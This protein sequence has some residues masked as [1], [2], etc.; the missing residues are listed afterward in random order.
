[1]STSIDEKIVAMK[2]N[3]SDF[4]NNAKRSLGTLAALTKGLKLDGA[5]KGIQ[6]ISAA[7]KGL[8]LDGVGSNV[9]QISSKFSALGVVGVTALAT[10]AN[11]AVNVGLN[12]VKSLTISPISQGF[13][14]YNEKL[15]SVNTV[16]NATGKSQ[17]VVSK[18]FNELDKYADLTIYNLQDMT[19]ALAKFVNAGISL[20]K[21]VP[22]I[23]GIANMTALA[24]QGAGA[25]SI[26]MYNL[27]QSLAG[28]FLTTTDYKSLNLANV[29]TKEWKDNMIKAAVSAGTLKRV[30]ADS[31]HIV[32][33][34]AG[35]A[36]TSAA[37]FNEKLSDGWANAKILLKVLGDYG[38]PLTAIGRKALAA[39]QEVKSLPM[40]LETLRA[41]VGT[42]WTDTFEIVVGNLKE[43]KK[44]FT[45]LTNYVGT[46]LGNMQKARND[47]LKAW[48]KNGGRD[49]LI[50]GLK[51]SFQA[52]L[53]IIKPIKDAFTQI[54]PP[55]TGKRLAEM[56]KN[57][58][59]FTAG[60]KLGGEN[61][62]R[63]KRTF[64]GVFA[65]FKV[66]FTII[67]TVV[68]TL[69]TLFGI[70][71]GGSG[72]FLALTASVGD[73]IVKISEWLT[74]SGQIKSFFATIDTAR[75]AIIVPLVAIVGKVAEAFAALFSGD[76]KGFFNGMKSA[77][78]GIGPLVNGIWK[79]ATSSISGYIA[80][81]RDATGVASEFIKG[82]GIKALEPIQKMLAKISE[83]FGK[84][85]VLISNFGF[86]LFSKS[87]AGASNS[88]SA[89]DSVGKKIAQVWVSIKEA[90]QGV[91]QAL[92]PIG[93]SIG[94][95][96]VTITD[97][98]A[99]WIDGMNMNDALAVVNTG[100]FIAMYHAA[101]KF[102]GNM[103]GILGGFKGI[104]KDIKDTLN[105]IKTSVT[106]TLTTM[107]KNVKANIILKISI[108]I[109]ILAASLYVLSNIDPVKLGTAITAIGVLLFALT[110]TMGAMLGMLDTVHAQAPKKMGAILA[111]GGA[112]LLLS[113]AVLALSFA[114]KNLAGLSW[115]EMAKGLTAT[116]VLLGA[117]GLYSK[118]ADT[119]A[120]SMKGAAS[121]A[122]LAGAVYLLTFS[123]SKL[124]QMD[125]KQLIQG[126]VAIT[127][128]IA[129]LAGASALMGATGPTGAAVILAF[130]VALSVISPILA[131]MG[132]LPY[133]V[134]AKGIG[135]IAIALGVLALASKLMGTPDSAL[136]AV[137]I[138]ALTVALAVLAPI[139]ALLGTLPYEVLAKGLGTIAIAL[140][141]LA[142]AA[143]LMG[144]PMALS[145]SIGIIAMAG[146]LALLAPVIL[147]LGQA[148][149]KT[150]AI[151]LGAIAV[152]FGILIVAGAAAVVVAPG[153]A[154][155]GLAIVAI[156][157]AMLLAG[158]G[159]LAFS[160]GF[161]ALVAVGT[162]G[163]A[164]LTTGFIG[165]LQLVPLMAQQI[166]LGIVAIAVV[167]TNAGPRLVAAITVVLISILKAIQNAAPQFFSTMITLILGLLKAIVIVAPQILA[168]VYQLFIK[169]ISILIQ[170]VPQFAAKGVALMLAILNA[171]GR[172]VSV[173]V[174]K[175]VSL[176][177]QLMDA[178][179]RHIPA[180][181]N[182]ATDLMIKFI[183][184]ISN[185]VPKLVD[186]GAKAVIRLV[187]GVADAIRNNTDEMNKA[188]AN[189]AG[190]IIEGLTSGIRNGL[191]AVGQAASEMASAAYEKA[192]SF[193]KINSPSKIFISLGKSVGEGFA[194]GIHG[195]KAAVD[196][197]MKS[198]RAVVAKSIVG[199][200]NDINRA[201]KRLN[202]L[203]KA[204]HKDAAAIRKAQAELTR[205]RSEHKKAIA[206]NNMIKTWGDE[207][208]KLGALA[209]S[210]D[211]VTARL[212]TAK[213]TL[214]DAIKTRDDFSKS[215]ADSYDNLPAIDKDTK[216]STFIKSLE[217]QVVDTQI[218]TAQLQQLRKMGLSDAVYEEL[219]AKG[220]DAMPFAKQ[221]LDG[222]QIK[223]NQVNSL[224]S[225]LDKAAKA[226]GSSASKA[227]YQ[228]GVDAAAGLVKG[229]ERQQAALAKQMD[230]LADAMVRAI[231]KKLGIKSPSRE[232]A[233]IGDWSVKGLAKGLE[234][235]TP[236][237]MAAAQKVG[238]STLESLRQSLTGLSEA[239]KSDIDMDPTIRPI[240]DLS[241]IKKDAH[242]IGSILSGKDISVGTAFARAKQNAYEHSSN[243]AARDQNAF[244]TAG[245]RQTFNQYNSSPK[246]L[247][248]A[249]IYRQTKN[250][251]STAK[252]ALKN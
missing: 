210:Y 130:A 10:I 99:S 2:L 9:D 129:V 183:N 65:I 93:D 164:V 40:A 207:Q 190:A 27:S 29:A 77:F 21:A 108:A 179:G 214:A 120:G 176:M 37:L 100:F 217:K 45:D 243:L 246:A 136:G 240:L 128:I 49:A 41:G 72:G 239:V 122:I 110:K 62:D 247:S 202:S 36:S 222:G 148:D 197:A 78:A 118:F 165:L 218:F 142:G 175:G 11:K 232:F 149:L 4:E 151:G 185:A 28:G 90:F 12:L 146:A 159:F 67:S 87:A 195:N 64:A 52:L 104:G 44:L 46:Y 157:G 8:N 150:L 31:F 57:F 1:M 125:T 194:K 24:G 54:F 199:T 43:S 13:S 26:A 95:L 75:L 80:K 39:A 68:K 170:Y 181:V 16:M 203:Y 35:T 173:I 236:A 220:T 141:L 135:T 249:T 193:L 216:L 112:I 234:S 153:L 48:K 166:G 168:S 230:K 105:V 19:G 92:G 14:D 229:L 113:F 186:A 30:G 140:G 242:Q 84:L 227:L 107:Q 163:F 101:K 61:A 63:L 132:T 215:T 200:Q 131:L 18:Y 208:K 97:K 245:V 32:G 251:I 73:F 180:I 198:L 189:L 192:K 201:Q 221:L 174:A 82:L 235:A 178:I 158:L 117:L 81:V 231:K 171:I 152:G 219:L 182:K 191:G 79:S 155:L 22:A 60:L 83:N 244:E 114:V 66:G 160:A 6:N 3:N 226:L 74:T 144:N 188:G 167:L 111:S 161:A 123:V 96:F 184:A 252:G 17:A 133:E 213:T 85:K 224:G 25:A 124:G 56:T 126:G 138:L 237:S 89:L 121:L 70:A 169:L 196:K 205:A 20:D 248:E 116:A 177:L 34:K 137:N 209:N 38:N 228:A 206:A 238:D 47:T 53:S 172:Y 102:I 156:G 204:R 225:S 15:T 42:G 50:D 211:K 58:R 76:Y 23:K 162:A 91:D 109:G 51:N 33:N 71:Q 134:L 103:D 55:V 143:Y 212:K 233:K 98:L 154:A 187:N 145:G 250:Q 127:A 86:D 241:S 7:A 59:D 119:G 106:D 94:K 69:L 115:Q 139:L 88:M 147:L 223:I 5:T